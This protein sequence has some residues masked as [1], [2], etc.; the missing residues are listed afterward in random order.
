M[1]G[2]FAAKCLRRPHPGI[3]SVVRLLRV[4]P[5]SLTMVALLLLFAVLERPLFGTAAVMRWDVGTGFEPLLQ[6]GHWWSL[7]TSLFFTANAGWLVVSILVVLFVL[8]F[9]EPLMGTA[10]TLLVFFVSGVTGTLVGVGAQWLGSGSGEFWSRHTTE[11]IALD[12]LVAV[13]GAVMAASCF[14]GTLWRR[15]IRILTLLVILVV[16][17]YSGQPSD[18]YRLFGAITGLCLGHFLTHRRITARWARGSQH[19][20]RVLLSAAV[21]ITAL[22]PAVALL[23][24]SRFGPLAPVVQL[25]FQQA[26]D[27]QTAARCQVF[28]VTAHCVRTVTLARIDNPGAI[29]VSIAPMLLLLIASYGLLRGRRLAV[30]AAATVNVLLGGLGAFYFGFLP[31]SDTPFAIPWRSTGSWE[32]TVGIVLSIALPLAIAGALI[33]LRRNFPVYS[34]RASVTGYVT[35]VIGSGL[36]LAGLYIAGG[37]MLRDTAFTTVVGL[38]SLLGDVLERFIPVSFLRQETLEFLPTTPLGTVLYYG[39]GPAFWLVAIAGVLWPLT[40]TVD[41]ALPGNNGIVRERLDQASGSLSFM[42]T[43][44]GTA[45]WFDPDSTAVIGYRLVGRVALTIGAPF[46]TPAPHDAV[47]HRFTRFCDHNGWVPVFYSLDGDYQG[48]FHSIGWPSIVVAEE[49]I[50]H[51]AGWSIAGK[52]WQDIRTSINRAERVGITAVW[53]SYDDLPHAMARQIAEISEQW[54]ADKSLP[55]MGFTLGGLEELRDRDVRLMLAI[56]NNGTVQAVTSWLP[57]RRNGAVIGWTLDFMRRRGDSP[58]GVMEFII[59]K[60]AERMRENG[61]E[62]L[63]LSGAP[64]AHTDGVQAANRMD[65]LLGF[66]S[67]SLEPVY[68][69]RSLLKFKRKFQPELRPMIMAYP[70]QALLPEIGLALT[71]AYLP[72]LSLRGAA[73]LLRAPRTDTQRTPTRAPDH[74]P[75]PAGQ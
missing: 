12:P 42:T 31:L 17:L 60:T 24:A 27:S 33:L 3:G 54:V 26:P 59:A 23:S 38:P 29:A 6:D 39:I 28:N 58:H 52:K 19:E 18:L 21:A 35:L 44:P 41:R 47:L 20:I 7:V 56:D 36:L 63:S 30:W 65:R 34:T 2:T 16:L 22:G 62:F 61:I 64:L 15:R 68:G 53:T 48:Y 66:L 9:V 55:E 14:T 45:H 43:W 57:A 71:R 46:G 75:A 49:T 4:R 1:S 37:L 13:A 67:A 50:I 72:Q 69:F 10:R 74:Q 8:G 11:F 5:F 40:H 32:I 25:L 70:D 73:T 51:P